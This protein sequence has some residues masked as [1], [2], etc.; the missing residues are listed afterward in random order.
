MD[1]V[2]SSL[3]TFAFQ[4]C[5]KFRTLQILHVEGSL[6][7]QKGPELQVHNLFNKPLTEV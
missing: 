3:C 1:G 4:V 6:P 5:L 7:G 2:H